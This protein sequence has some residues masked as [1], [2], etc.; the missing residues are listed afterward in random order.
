MSK[1]KE[2]TEG[3][4]RIVKVDSRNYCVQQLTLCYT[5][6]TRERSEEERKQPPG[7]ATLPLRE[8]TKSGTELR[9][10]DKGYYGNNLKWAAESALMVQVP[11]G[12]ALLGEFQKAAQRVIDSM[13]GK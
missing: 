1:P 5:Y 12:V 3:A 9:W 4:V 7:K 8:R 10:E 6:T 11:E 2:P 13:G